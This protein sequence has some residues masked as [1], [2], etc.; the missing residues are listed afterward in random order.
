VLADPLK[1][2]R[3]PVGPGVGSAG[4]WPLRAWCTRVR[5]G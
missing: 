4:R 5:R 3:R 2:L 1:G